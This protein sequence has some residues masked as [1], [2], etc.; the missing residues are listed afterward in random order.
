M[1]DVVGKVAARVLQGRLQLLAEDLLPESQCGFRKERSCTDM[2]FL[3][4]QLLEKSWEHRA[5]VFVTFV[6]LRKGQSLEELS[7]LLSGN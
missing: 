7:G 2:I 1:L 6:D 5:K 3:I 4:R